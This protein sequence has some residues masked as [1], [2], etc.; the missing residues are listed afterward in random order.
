MDR[1][2]M[3]SPQNLLSDY[4]VSYQER[5]ESFI[6]RSWRLG[7]IGLRFICMEKAKA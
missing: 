3:K 6:W 7:N 1:Q 5:A 2:G 4:D